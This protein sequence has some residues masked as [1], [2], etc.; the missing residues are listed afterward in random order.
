V[1]PGETDRRIYVG[2]HY[3][4]V[5]EGE[6]IIDNWT[7]ASLLPTLYWS[8]KD[9]PPKHTFVFAG[10]ADEERGLLGSRSHVKRLGKEQVR[11]GQHRYAR[12]PLDGVS[13]DPAGDS[14]STPFHQR[15][16]PTITF[17]SLTQE[18]L[19]VL[20]ASADTMAKLDA[21]AY[22]DSYRLL[23]AYLVYLDIE[24]HRSANAPSI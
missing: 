16:I 2:A 3:D 5:K 13:V 4:A 24:L 20:H 10:F 1:L 14:D 22:Y 17:H 9:K 8:L 19:P 6:G 18:T 11:H 15:K 7:G 12:V 23:S 21:D